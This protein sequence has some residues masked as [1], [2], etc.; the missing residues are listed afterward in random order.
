MNVNRKDLLE[1]LKK[2]LSGIETGATILE[3]ADTFVFSEGRILSYN[4]N[5]SVS[6]PFEIEGGEIIGAIKALE[7]FTLINRFSEETIKITEKEGKWIIRSG[8]AKAEFVLLDSSIL[9]RVNKIFPPDNE[10]K[11]LPDN[12]FRGI[13]ICKIPSNKSSLSGYFVNG[14]RLVSTDTV[15]IN[16]YNLDREMEKFWVS[17]TSINELEKLSK[18]SFYALTSSW[19]H[20]KTED[21][22]IFSC[23]RLNDESY[24][25]DKILNVKEKNRKEGEVSFTFPKRLLDA[26]YRA[27]VLSTSVENFE[28]IDISFSSENIIIQSERSSGKYFERVS[29]DNSV[30]I[31]KEIEIRID[32]AM[33]E[34][35]MK[36]A[37]SFYIKEESEDNKRIVFEYEEG[38][39]ILGIIRK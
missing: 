30:S 10:W 11:S 18:I 21:G 20:F 8:E 38:L 23:K 28:T 34:L 22:V 14:N 36:Q 2:C 4:D 19:V 1:A 37:K 26:I 15:R 5:I 6:V 9:E 27:S 32:F 29:W 31:D 35:A 13:K 16:F 3:G 39:Q 24:P 33:M 25:E 12:F 17:D 7:F